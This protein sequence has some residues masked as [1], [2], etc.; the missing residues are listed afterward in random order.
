MTVLVLLLRKGKQQCR[1]VI[2]GPLHR[3]QAFLLFFF[4]QN[5]KNRPHHSIYNAEYN[6]LSQRH[7]NIGPQTK[8]FYMKMY[9]RVQAIVPSIHFFEHKIGKFRVAYFLASVTDSHET[10]DI[11]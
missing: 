1:T 10:L 3:C 8:Q 11:S 6:N 9:A 7:G 2:H 5:K 4:T